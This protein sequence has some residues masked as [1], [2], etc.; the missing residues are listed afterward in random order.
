MTPYG[1]DV[2]YEADKQ[3]EGASSILR[4]RNISDEHE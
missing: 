1:I 2:A 3:S 4:S